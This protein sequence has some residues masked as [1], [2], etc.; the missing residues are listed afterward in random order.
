MLASGMNLAVQ[1]HLLLLYFFVACIEFKIF[2]YFVWIFFK[3][4]FKKLYSDV[5][6]KAKGCCL[7][8]EL[9]RECIDHQFTVLNISIIICLQCLYMHHPCR[10]RFPQCYIWHFIFRISNLTFTSPQ[11]AQPTVVGSPQTVTSGNQTIVIPSSGTQYIIVNS[12]TPVQTSN[13]PV[14]QPIRIIQRGQSPQASQ[15]Q[16]LIASPQFAASQTAAKIVLTQGLSPLKSIVDNSSPTSSPGRG[17]P[18]SNATPRPVGRGTV[19][20]R[21]R[22]R[23]ANSGRGNNNNTRRQN[24]FVNPHSVQN[25][26]PTSSVFV[27]SKNCIVK[28]G[29]TSVQNSQHFVKAMSQNSMSI[30]QTEVGQLNGAN[31]NTQQTANNSSQENSSSSSQGNASLVEYSDSDSS[32]KDI[33][34]VEPSTSQGALG[35]KYSNGVVPVPNALSDAIANAKPN[36]KIQ[37]DSSLKFVRNVVYKFPLKGGIKFYRYDGEFLVPNPGKDI[38]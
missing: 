6:D 8:I 27:H 28:A 14:T 5:F 12:G 11:K 17:R 21:V 16:A 9:K 13:S 32:E 29:N 30:I 23:G 38:Q 1:G 31:T 34:A 3:L 2:C 19:N 7:L 33:E 18:V 10:D 20:G 26:P 22:S 4:F 35:I 37:V 25:R 15:V 24:Y 36:Q